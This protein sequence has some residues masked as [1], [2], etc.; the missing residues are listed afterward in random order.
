M[1]IKPRVVVT[2]HGIRT[3]GVW[4]KQITPHLARHGLVPYHIDYGFFW[5][6]S[7]FCGWSRERRLATVRNE[8]RALVGQVGADRISVIAHSFGTWLAMEVL[9]RE[10]GSIRYD[11]VVLTGSIV[12]LDFDWTAAI[13][14]RW[15]LA[16][17]NERST[18]DGVVRLASWISRKRWLRWM[19]GGLDAGASGADPFTHALP[20][21]LDDFIVGGHSETHNAIKFERWA[22]F[23]A[24]PHLP[25]D[26]LDRVVVELQV[27]RQEAA[28]L[29]GIAPARVRA[30]LAAPFEGSLRIVPGAHDNMTWAPEYDL[31]IE[32]GHGST[33]AAFESGAA[34][35]AV[36][37][38]ESWSGNHLPG[39]ELAKLNPRLMWVVSLPVTSEM[40]STVVGVVN[41]DGLDA[42]P[43]LLQDPD[44]QDFNA[45][46]LALHLGM[47]ERFR[48]CLEAAFRGDRLA[49]A[50]G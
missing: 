48:P 22:R 24:Y 41:I 43:D 26:L 23:I 30:N 37:R 17:R 2:I 50:G 28:R 18:L 44:S 29:F 5:A 4:Q 11:R 3:R 14:A 8:M 15:V 27:L 7:F 19:A 36:R 40:R 33:G 46:L 39:S 1:H 6:L 47:L 38:G 34:C 25:D 35:A 45:A 10:N 20:Q 42:I 16:A 31:R 9:R 32:S 13:R 12:P 49:H 21:L